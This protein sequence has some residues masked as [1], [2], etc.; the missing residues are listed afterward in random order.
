[1]AR[2]PNYSY[3]RFERERAKAAKRQAKADA[4]ASVRAGK[5]EG[6]APA[7]ESAADA[8]GEQLA[9]DER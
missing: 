2:K 9:R 7:G 1:M 3:E 6:D 5:R 8:R 4:K